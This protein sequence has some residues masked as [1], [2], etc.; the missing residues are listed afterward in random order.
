MTSFSL[1]RYITRCRRQ[2]DAALG[3][4]LPRASQPPS[5]IHRAMR[6]SVLSGGK[7]LRPI[8]VLAAAEAC[9]GDARRVLPT[10]CA[11]E[12]IHTYSLIHDDLPAMDDDDLRRGRPTNHK[13]F[14]ESIAI[15][16]G[17]ALLT[18]AFALIRENGRTKGVKPEAVLDVIA[19]VAGGAGTEGM[20][21]GQVAD[22]QSDRGRWR[23]SKAPAQL[24]EFIHRKKTAALIRSSLVAGGRLAGATPRQL[25]ALAAF[26]TGIGLAFQVKDDL[27]DR[28]GDKM[29]LGKNG[30]DAANQKLTYP[31]VYGMQTSQ[32]KA[33][34]LIRSAHRALSIFG[35][36]AD[37]L[38]Q[39]ADYVL[40]RDR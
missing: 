21:G 8:L 37:T 10:A 3:R 2:V 1:P 19:M 32:R 26:G 22:V 6:Y 29:K 5:V 39:L 23:R 17:D 40:S 27:L 20:I 13:V 36:K 30:S 14:G 7:R 15:L 38:H 11:L 33:A 24:L 9:G 31:A 35:A 28:T 16:A 34:L 25:K 4:L 12:L 18:L